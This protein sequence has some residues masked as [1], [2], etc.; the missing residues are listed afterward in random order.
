[1]KLSLLI[2]VL[3]FSLLGCQTQSTSTKETPSESPV[4][5]VV[6]GAETGGASPKFS[7]TSPDG[8]AINFDPAQNPDNEAF[9]ILFWSQRWDPNV[10]T[11]L[12]RTSELHE[13]YAPRGLT[14]IA[15]SYDDE[16]AELRTFLSQNALPFEVAVG[17]DTTS[18]DF[19]VES[20]PTS[21]LVDSNGR[22]VDRWTGY[23]D[24]E[25]LAKRISPHLPGRNGNSDG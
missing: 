20:V 21:I 12:Q 1:M 19:E 17:S 6:S 3:T 8:N 14:I 7:L 23:F 15:V 11:L 10:K 24:T 13:R 5:G 25:E 16:P 4:S 2:L 9:L 18:K 22:I